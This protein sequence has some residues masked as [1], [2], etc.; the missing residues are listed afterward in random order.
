MSLLLLLAVIPLSF[1]IGTGASAIGVTAWMLL[2]PIL[3]IVFGFDLYL[4]MPPWGN[5]QRANGQIGDKKDLPEKYPIRTNSLE[6]FG[7]LC[8]N[9]RP[10]GENA[11]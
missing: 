5:E 2:V 4:T 10:T 11:S 8:Q 3:F 7:F 9:G 1:V 6:P